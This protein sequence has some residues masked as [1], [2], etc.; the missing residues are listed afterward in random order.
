GP[1]SRRGASIINGEIMPRMKVGNALSVEPTNRWIRHSAVVL[2]TD[3]DSLVQEL[4]RVRAREAELHRENLHQKALLDPIRRKS[5]QLYPSLE[6]DAAVAKLAEDINEVREL[7]TRDLYR[8][9]ATHICERAI[10]DLRA[11]REQHLEMNLSVSVVPEQGSHLR[12]LVAEELTSLFKQAGIN[13]SAGKPVLT[14]TNEYSPIRITMNPEDVTLAQEIVRTIAN[15]VH[16]KFSGN[17]NE[18]CRRGAFTI[19]I[20][21]DPLFSP[22]GVV[23]FK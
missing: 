20:A 12:I 10:A 21:G 4:D 1:W 3:K 6:T 15:F 5:E 23:T 17:K 8:P 7:A 22:D 18:D 19:R 11:F 16:A 13:A 2:K 9:L 14:F